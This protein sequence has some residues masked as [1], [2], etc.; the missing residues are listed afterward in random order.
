MGG[1]PARV[2]RSIPLPA[3]RVGPALVA[4]LS[5]LLVTGC[6]SQRVSAHLH[7]PPSRRHSLQSIFQAVPQLEVDPSG[8][9][10]TLKK[11]GVDRV[12]VVLPWNAIAPDPSSAGLPARFDATDPAAY[13]ARNWA[14]YDT[15][16]RDAAARGIG[17]D[18]TLSAPPPRWAEGRGAPQPSAH[19]Y[20][21]PSAREFG[22][23]VKA[24]ATRYSGRYKASRVSSRLPRVDFWAIWNEPNYGIYLA[25]QAT[26]N[27][28]IEVAPRL[29]RGL[30]DAAWTALH[31]TG[32][33]GDTI[34]IG[35]LA[36]RGITV[37]SNLYPGN[38]SGMVPLRFLR[39]L[40]CVDSSY[41][42]LRGAAATARGCPASA[43][44]TAAFAAVHPALFHA[45][46]FSDH[47]YPQEMAPNV[48][49][50][51]EPDYTD[52]PVLP[53]L[54]RVLDTLQRAYGSATHLPIYSTEYGYRTD[55]PEVGA[56]PGAQA[57]YYLNWA[58]YVSWRDP[59]V[60]S[61]DQYELID[62]GGTSFPTGLL[63]A[64]GAPKP[65]FYAYRLALYL[66]VTSTR[67]GQ[68]LE[69]WGCVRPARF[70]KRETG[71]NQQ[72]KIQFEPDSRGPFR[73]VRTLT[74]RDPSGY[75][76]VLQRFASSGAVRLTWSYPHGPAVF[77]RTVSVMIR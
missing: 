15:I 57:A 64:D 39:A 51:G 50:P 21:K 5:V 45:S 12:R 36:P 44:G 61:Y 69:V 24:V 46:G 70:A 67:A 17:L 60:R 62:S 7:L 31:A 3:L 20:W 23:F 4:V 34:L 76:D 1:Y 65:T 40:Y 18:L 8:T 72:V 22:D 9:L 30:V 42:S 59:L 63:F 43:A 19:T 68:P 35:E 77:S 10:D 56:T 47:P 53:R 54:E 14:I 6:G 75:F 32:H 71:R 37:P 27:S 52:L 58:Q 74:L 16:V 41:H 29:Y 2:R 13:P 38:F 25:P 49:T 66:P 26:D 33:G 55:P 11:L 73:A 48:G 28:T